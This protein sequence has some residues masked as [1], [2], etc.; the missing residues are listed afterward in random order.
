MPTATDLDPEE[1]RAGLNKR[2]IVLD[3]STLIALVEL[4]D[5]DGN[6]KVDAAEFKVFL[7]KSQ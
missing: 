4:L 2:G 1:L 7:T 6:G 3:S 5:K